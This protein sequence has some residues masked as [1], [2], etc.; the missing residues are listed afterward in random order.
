MYCPHCHNKI[1]DGSNIC[2]LCYANLA[3][4][5]PQQVKEPAQAAGGD[6]AGE[7]G[8]AGATGAVGATGA[9]GEA[10]RQTKPRT[11]KNAYTKGSRGS[12]R[13]ADRTPMLV[14]F[15]LI[16]ILVVIVVMIVRSMFAGGTP[17]IPGLSD[18]PQPQV[19]LTPDTNNLIVFGATPTPQA[20]QV[21]TAPPALEV[22]PTPSPVPEFSYD[23]L[24][25]GDVG[26][27][28]VSMQQALIELGYLT[29][30]ADG[31]FGSGTETAV[32]NFQQA[33]G[34]T[35]DGIA[36]RMTLEALFDQASVTPIP[37]TEVTPAPGEIL[38]LPG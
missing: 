26:R 30:S 25:K 8:A 23:T 36:G 31:N 16:V 6:A 2:P 9:A 33:S 29:G 14:A 21:V 22:T 18:T 34:L 12:R 32:K 15:G 4:I 20:Q 38:N 35:V 7:A 13:S 1:P 19:D 28:V 10:M 11:K 27:N 5:R 24:R 17:G 37:Q 3:G